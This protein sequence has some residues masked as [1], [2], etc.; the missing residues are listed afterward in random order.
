MY[1]SGGALLPHQEPRGGPKSR[2]SGRHHASGRHDDVTVLRLFAKEVSVVSFGA[3]AGVGRESPK[4]RATV[5]F[6]KSF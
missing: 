6:K 3:G 5:G 4:A 2:S 1:G